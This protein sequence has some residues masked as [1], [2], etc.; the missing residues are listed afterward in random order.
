MSKHNE[1]L[2]KWIRRRKYELE[3]QKR[4]DDDLKRAESHRRAS[5]RASTLR[6]LFGK[7]K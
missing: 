1:Q 6:R 3:Q 7:N 4:R 2:D 5:E